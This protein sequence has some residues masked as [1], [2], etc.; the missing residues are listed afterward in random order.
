[1]HQSTQL[2]AN[3]PGISSLLSLSQPHHSRPAH[4][5]SHPQEQT[6][7]DIN[8]WTGLLLNH[9][10]QQKGSITFPD[11]EIIL[12]EIRTQWDALARMWF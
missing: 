11:N 6:I 12:T 10:S 3:V 7:D 4:A 9:K 2:T 8:I 5:A 1:M